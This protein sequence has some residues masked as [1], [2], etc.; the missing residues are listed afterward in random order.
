M[1]MALSSEECAAIGNEGLLEQR[2]SS[3]G[4]EILVAEME[5]NSKSA[6]LTGQSVD[7]SDS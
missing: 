5:V 1:R 6:M 4:S 2:F 7:E 3:A